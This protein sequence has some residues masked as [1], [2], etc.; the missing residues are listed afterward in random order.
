MKNFEFSSLSEYLQI[1]ANLRRDF[2]CHQSDIWFRGINDDTLALVPGVIW[3]KIAE[4]RE[5]SMIAE[6]MTY[7]SNYTNIRPATAFDC[8][9]LMQHYGLP[10]RFLD[11]STSPLVSLYF[12]LEKHDNKKQ[13]AVWAINPHPMNLKSINYEAVI[14]PNN[15]KPSIITKYLPKYLRD[16]KEPVPETPVA[17]CV[18][19][20][21]QRVT[22]QKGVFTLHGFSS[23]PID[24]FYERNKIPAIAKLR[25]KS[26]NLRENILTDLY[27]AGIKEDDIYQDLNSLSNRII[28]EYGA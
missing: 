25:L 24:K 11:W 3:R 15:F 10:T 2:D 16:S 12:S 28:R 9:A 19:L 26:E 6:F 18:P 4:N 14:A 8:Y 23:E 1:V 20:Q 22:S 5:Q 7:F 27:S 17:V 21:N 13:R